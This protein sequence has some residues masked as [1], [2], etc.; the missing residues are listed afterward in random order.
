MDGIPWYSLIK[1]KHYMMVK[2]KNFAGLIVGLSKENKTRREMQSLKSR[3]FIPALTSTSATRQA[4]KTSQL[5]S[6]SH[7]RRRS[8]NSNQGQTPQ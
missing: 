5:Q 2:L 6:K 3:S 8:I 1:I 7:N 4:L